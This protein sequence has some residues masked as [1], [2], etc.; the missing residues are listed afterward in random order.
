MLWSSHRKDKRCEQWGLGQIEEAAQPE[1]ISRFSFC[2]ED[3][4]RGGGG[5]GLAACSSVS[6]WVLYTMGFLSAAEGKK[7]A[8]DSTVHSPAL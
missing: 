6:V 2:S 4:R 8:C 7:E 5:R 1:R 3:T